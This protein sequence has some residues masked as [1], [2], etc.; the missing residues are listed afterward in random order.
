MAFISL[1]FSCVND[2]YNTPK[3]DCVNPNLAKNKEVAAIYK[4][5]TATTKAYTED[6]I[7]EAYVISSDEGGN[8]FK[9]MYL[10]S[11]DGSVGFNLSIDEANL[12]TKNF[13]PGRKV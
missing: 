3:F 13:P 9:S 10:Q 7:I 5:A 2:S 1:C 12:Y 4:L 11:T 8:F 6:D